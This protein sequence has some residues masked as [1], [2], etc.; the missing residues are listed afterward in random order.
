MNIE[1]KPHVILQGDGI[2]IEADEALKVMDAII[3]G[4]ELIIVK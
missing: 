1:V 4:A 2:L 3:D